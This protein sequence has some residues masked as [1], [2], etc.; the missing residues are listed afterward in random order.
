MS[1]ASRFSASL[2]SGGLL[3]KV[4]M[5]TLCE[6]RLAGPEAAGDA[7]AFGRTETAH[8]FIRGQNAS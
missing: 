3:K 8:P 6:A 7:R 2:A 4:V 5:E 1:V